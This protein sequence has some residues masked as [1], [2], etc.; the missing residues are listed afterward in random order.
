MDIKTKILEVLGKGH[1]MSLATLDEGGLWVADV[2]YIYDDLNIYWMSDPD[3]RHSQAILKNPQV[4]GS[5]TVTCYGEKPE[6]GIQFSGKAEKINGPNYE[7][8]KKH[9]SKRKQPEPKETDDVLQGDSWYVLH[10][11][12]IDLI[13][14]ENYGFDKRSLDL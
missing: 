1:L 11:T 12:K 7:L 8:A 13:D 5:I 14:V 6:V 2:I 4:A 10:P 3:V 9:L